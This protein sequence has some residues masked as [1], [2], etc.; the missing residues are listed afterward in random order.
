MHPW[1]VLPDRGI[2][3]QDV[4]VGWNGMGDDPREA[5]LEVIEYDA[6]SQS[7]AWQTSD[8]INIEGAFQLRQYYKTH[9]SRFGAPPRQSE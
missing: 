8:N 9:G 1:R 5:Y 7:V 6:E 3:L 2:R 4:L